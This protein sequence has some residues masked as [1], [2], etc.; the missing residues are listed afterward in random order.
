VINWDVLVIAE[1]GRPYRLRLRD[2]TAADVDALQGVW[3]P[4]LERGP[5]HWLDRDWHWDRLDAA[6]E[7]AFDVD[8]EWLVLA[9]DVE[10]AGA[11]DLLG[12]LVTTGPVTPAQASL[13][14]A[15]VGDGGIVWVEYVAI[16][17]SIRDDCPTLDRRSAQLKGV[18]AQLMMAAIERSKDLGCAGRV[19][20]HAEGEVAV[21]A[22]TK[23]EMLKFPDA[24]H[25]TGGRFPVFFGD[26]AWAKD[27]DARRR[28]RA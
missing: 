13:E 25:P 12:V 16:A 28:V 19:G 18:G 22:Y 7:L 23:W 21:R 27:F 1:G 2:C 5:R 4:I 17:P 15:V 10:Q 3:E 9:D 24:S 6:E 26:A 20:L 11:R 8:P 14:A